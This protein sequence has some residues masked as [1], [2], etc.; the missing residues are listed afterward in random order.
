[1]A[2][3]L[4]RFDW[5]VGFMT[6][7]LLLLGMQFM[8]SI[9]DRA[10]RAAVRDIQSVQDRNLVIEEGQLEYDSRYDP[11]FSE[12]VQYDPQALGDYR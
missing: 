2:G 7:L 12:P 5:K 1:M 4:E 8:N 9:G 3:L 10:T 6:M 11:R